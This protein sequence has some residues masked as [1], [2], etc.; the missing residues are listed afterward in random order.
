VEGHP[1]VYTLGH[2]NEEVKYGFFNELLAIYLPAKDIRGDFYVTNFGEDLWSHN[3]E[4]F[5]NRL[6]AFFFGI[7]YELNNKAEKH[8]QTVFYILFTLPGQFVRVEYLIPFTISGKQ[9]V[10]IGVEFGENERGI[11]RWVIEIN[12]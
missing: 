1:N 8:Y 9:L 6:K 2:P 3:M 7:P 4:G 11:K 12:D 5:M 10:K